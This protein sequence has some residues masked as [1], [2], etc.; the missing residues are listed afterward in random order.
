MYDCSDIEKEAMRNK[1]IYNGM[2]IGRIDTVNSFISETVKNKDTGFEI[3]VSK[4]AK[5]HIKIH[6]LWDK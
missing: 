5:D 4:I 1:L 2:K 3:S 6:F